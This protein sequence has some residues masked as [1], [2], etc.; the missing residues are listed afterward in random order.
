MDSS[1]SQ[2]REAPRWR[3]PA[4][5]SAPEASRP[6]LWRRALSKLADWLRPAW[7]SWVRV[8]TVFLSCSM[9]W[10]LALSSAYGRAP[11]RCAIASMSV[12]RKHWGWSIES[13]TVHCQKNGTVQGMK[14]LYNDRCRYKPSQRPGLAV[15]TAQPL[16]PPHPSSTPD[17]GRQAGTSTIA[18]HTFREVSPPAA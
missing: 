7:S 4:R 13:L 6:W 8:W 17:H 18:R 9:A 2:V 14:G 5:P 11:S 15:E 3:A 1:F 10:N 12:R 16:E